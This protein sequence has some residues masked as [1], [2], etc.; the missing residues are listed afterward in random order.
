MVPGVLTQV[1][2]PRN[3]KG[4][5]IF[6]ASNGRTQFC[7]SYDVTNGSVTLPATL[8]I[9]AASSPQTVVKLEIRGYDTLSDDYS[10][11]GTTDVKAGMGAPRILKRS[12]QSFVDQHIIYLPMTLSY[13][14]YDV[15]CSKSGPGATCKG[16]QCV[17]DST[18]DPNRL[19]D[20]APELID[21]T[22]QV[23]F[24]PS[25]C[26]GDM[27]PAKLLDA[28]SCTYGFPQGTPPGTGVNVR[29]FYKDLVWTKNAITNQYEQELT[30]GGEVEILD[31]DPDEGFTLVSG[32]PQ[33]K[34]APGLCQLATTR[35]D[36][37]SSGT[38]DFRIIS[39]VQ[40]ASA[41]AAKTSTIPVCQPEQHPTQNL[42][43]GGTTSDGKCNIAVPV[44]PVPSTVYVVMDDSKSMGTAFDPGGYAKVLSDSFNNPVFKQTTLAFKFLTHQNSECDPVS[45]PM[46]G[47][48]APD[49]PFGL[50]SAVGSAIGGKISGRMVPDPGGPPFAPLDLEAAMRVDAGTY[51]AVGTYLT[52]REPQHVAGV[53][54]FVNRA[55]DS[56]AGTGNDCNPP[57]GT[58]VTLASDAVQQAAVNA[59]GKGLR[60]FVVALDDMNHTQAALN[61]FSSVQTLANQM[62]G[63]PAMT[64]INATYSDK[65]LVA[66]E[67]AKLYELGTC[68]Y[69][70]PP[71]AT[72]S[73]VLKYNDPLA[74]L[75]N[76][77]VPP[78]T[79]DVTVP[80]DATC[81][82]ATSD[83]ANGW[84]IENGTRIR[85]CGASDQLACGKLRLAMKTTTGYAIS[86]NLPAPDFPVSITNLCK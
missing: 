70:R 21:G 86:K 52:G 74:S 77:V 84:A 69:E 43:D 49:V 7:Q 44:Q 30:G 19:A 81:S 4:I 65:L 24:S 17:T 47:Y 58:N 80:Y 36:P 79:G 76:A 53:A 32:Q 66:N 42:P 27:V 78:G 12:I 20:F 57:I 29:V 40:V 15:D 13:S 5:T 26:F 55:P 25:T 63:G 75:A 56:T 62:A 16:G 71:G 61:F 59:F 83:T 67:F 1:Q 6:I 51:A 45:S 23:C 11:C 8:G 60:T 22:G 38:L 35:P 34:L 85:I 82:A 41:C 46:T 28:S 72:E 54:F 64:V 2:V 3:L 73:S 37:P 50:A 39:D 10:S 9:T 33:F 48:Q 31:Q 68:L 14:C 18:I